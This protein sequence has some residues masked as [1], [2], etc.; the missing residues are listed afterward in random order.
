MKMK[1]TLKVGDI[2]YNVKSLRVYLV[3]QDKPYHY[4]FFSF[5]NIRAYTMNSPFVPNDWC[6]VSDTD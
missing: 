3:L 4:I 2:I 5:S 6:D 1:K